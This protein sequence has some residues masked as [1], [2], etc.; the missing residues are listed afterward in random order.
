MSRRGY[1]MNRINFRTSKI[2]CRI[3]RTR[4]TCCRMSRIG[5]R[6]S[7]ISCRMSIIG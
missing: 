6:T 4:R 1:G 2:G 5:S 3:G 7:R